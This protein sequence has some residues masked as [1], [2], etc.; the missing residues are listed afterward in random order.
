M[1][2]SN[3]VLLLFGLML[4]LGIYLIP[5]AYYALG[6]YPEEVR[7]LAARYPYTTF[8]V[9]HLNTLN[10]ESEALPPWVYRAGEWA[11]VP[12]GLDAAVLKGKATPAGPL[13]SLAFLSGVRLAAY[14]LLLV[15]LVTAAAR[16]SRT[17]ALATAGAGLL[18]LAGMAYFA[19]PRALP[20]EL[21]GFWK[22]L[23]T[24]AYVLELPAGER[25]ELNL[26]SSGAQEAWAAS[27]R[28]GAAA[29]QEL[30]KERGGRLVTLEPYPRL[31]FLIAGLALLGALAVGLALWLASEPRA[32]PA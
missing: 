1:Q 8:E 11:L 6:G 17:L 31:A 24:R 25:P 32:N 18:L 2:R 10:A 3:A 28:W 19:L 12:R 14:A 29:L 23:G 30:A 22:R 4:V 27:D 15:F 16:A 21:E 13:P 20:G 9:Y 7:A 5:T 26:I